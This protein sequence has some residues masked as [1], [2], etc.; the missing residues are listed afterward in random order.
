MHKQSSASLADTDLCL[1]KIVYSV[2]NVFCSLTMHIKLSLFAKLDVIF[3][4]MLLYANNP[5]LS[6]QEALL[7]L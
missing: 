7:G 5:K 4:G 3:K 1:T 6:G 2:P